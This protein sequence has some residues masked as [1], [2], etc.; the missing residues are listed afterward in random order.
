MTYFQIFGEIYQKKK[1]FIVAYVTFCLLFS[2]LAF[3]N[4]NNA[5]AASEFTSAEILTSLG[6]SGGKMLAPLTAAQSCL[7]GMDASTTMFLLCATSF[8]LDFIPESALET[9][10]SALDIEGLESLSTY[11]FGILDFTVFR[12]FCVV[13][14]IVD[15]LSKSNGISQEVAK[16]LG[17]FESLLTIV[18][19]VMVIGSQFLANVPL[20]STA[21]AASFDLEGLE[22]ITNGFNSVIC[23]FALMCISVIYFFIR[24]FF[25]FIDIVLIPLCTFV[26]MTSFGIEFLKTVTVT[27]LFLL[28]IFNPM[29]F[30]G[31]LAVIFIIS[32]IF[33]R[34][35]YVTIRYFKRIYI[36]P[37]FRRI[38]GY[39]RNIQLVKPKYPKQINHYV[40]VE[41]LQL[42][43]PVYMLKKAKNIKQIRLH[44]RWW[45]VSTK[46]KQFL[47]K[48]RLFK[49]S[50]YCIDLHNSQRNKIFIKKSLRFFEIFNLQGLETDMVRTFYKVPK[51]I[52]FAFSKEY[53][54][55]FD[56]IKALTS[57]TDY[58]EYRKELKLAL[59][60]TRLEKKMAKKVAAEERLMN[61]LKN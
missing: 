40:N 3:G 8:A 57:Y 32:V 9:F 42:V 25:Y 47:C 14:F 56:E 49:N 58:T 16:I 41:D 55:R 12:I 34:K 4:G 27:C 1:K 23:F 45:L 46:D 38:I 35:A 48:P 59:K 43:I 52:H 7:S 53:Y 10:G 18:V 50:C 54:H 5:F 30:Y 24:F 28:A 39:K 6:G 20:G 36:K 33:F 15:K 13:W 17:D 2:I 11:S 26:P 21:Y 31:I 44:E 37:F 22:V 29:I 19:N 60:S 61:K 51:H